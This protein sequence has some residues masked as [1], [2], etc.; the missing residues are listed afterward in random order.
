MLNEIETQMKML[1]E[2]E[3]QMKMLNGM[4]FLIFLS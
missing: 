2:I 3:T 4:L 1:H